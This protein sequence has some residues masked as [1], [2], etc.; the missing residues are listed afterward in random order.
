M[1]VLPQ[2]ECPYSL[3]PH[4]IQGLDCIHIYPVV[5]VGKFR[6][7]VIIEVRFQWFVKKA[8]EGRVARADQ[9]E[10]LISTITDRHLGRKV[11]LKEKN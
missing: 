2:L 11:H 5:Q 4:Q 7:Y 10:T 9:Q 3:E 8:M 1:R 6:G